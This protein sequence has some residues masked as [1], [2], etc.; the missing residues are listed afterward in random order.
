MAVVDVAFI[1][2][3]NDNLMMLVQQKGSRLRDTV[4]VDTNFTGEYKFYDQLGK[5]DFEQILN[6]HQATPIH[7]PAHERRRL[8]KQTFVRNVLLD[9]NDELNMLLDPTSKYSLSSAYSAGRKIDSI[10]IAAAVATAYEGKEGGTSTTLA[11]YDSGS[12]VIANG[13]T[14]LTLAKILQ[15]KKLFDVADVDPD[16]ERYWITTGYEMEDLLNV[17]EVKSA[18]Y[19]SVKALV[20]GKVDTFLGFKFK[21]TNLLT[22][23][24]SITTN[25]AYTKTAMMLGISKELETRITERSDKNYSTQ[26]WTMLSAG[27]TRL[28][29]EKLCSIGCSSS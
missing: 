3:Y 9:K 20:E 22:R 13:G 11:S 2:Q 8:T 23:A 21:M 29:E 16:E 28:E 26:V 5:G 12:H 10:I 4:Q 19:N 15:V 14:S 7:D 17:T 24:S 6:R 27:A 1:R 18:D 25:L